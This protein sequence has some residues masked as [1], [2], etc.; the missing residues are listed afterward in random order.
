MTLFNAIADLSGLRD[1]L[2]E[3]N[4]LLRRIAEAL[5]RVSP[6]VP[7][8]AD[9]APASDDASNSAADGFHL[10]ES[11]EQYQQRIDSEADLAISLGVAPW[12]PAF[13]ESV[14]QMRADLMRPR[15]EKDEETGQTVERGGYSEVEA[16]EIVKEAFQI[17]KSAANTY[18]ET[19]NDDK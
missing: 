12:S 11:P 17:A 2:T 7:A 16:S 15:R 5:E 6:V 14:R 4:S 3:T 8:A 13:Q 18:V 1:E 9:P 10:A 19:R